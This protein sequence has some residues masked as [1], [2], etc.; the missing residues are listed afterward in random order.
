MTGGITSWA[1]LVNSWY[2]S[3]VPILHA[4]SCMQM[5]L[6]VV[7]ECCC[8]FMSEFKSDRQMMLQRRSM[9][10]TEAMTFLLE[11]YVRAQENAMKSMADMAMVGLDAN[12][13]HRL[14]RFLV[15]MVAPKRS[16]FLI[17]CFKA[18][19]R[20]HATSEV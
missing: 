7:S 14:Q 12:A 17:V 20:C 16:V 11:K 6:T 13:H 19:T 8:S 2:H 1:R 15:E 9:N 3:E 4:N 5:L 10:E 18:W